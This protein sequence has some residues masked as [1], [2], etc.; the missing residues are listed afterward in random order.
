MTRERPSSA[1]RVKKPKKTAEHQIV[2]SSIFQPY[3]TRRNRQPTTTLAHAATAS[4]T[5]PSRRAQLQGRQVTESTQ[6]PAM[7]AALEAEIKKDE[8]PESKTT[9]TRR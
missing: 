4:R 9:E 1:Y 8:A 5:S 3:G 2:D 6:A 7:A